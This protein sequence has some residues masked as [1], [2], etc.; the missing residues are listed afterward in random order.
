MH[1]T[2]PARVSR[3]G[4]IVMALASALLFGASTPLAKQLLS[5]VSPW[6][7]AGVLY[8]GSGLGLL[9][10]RLARRA[11]RVQLAAG[12]ARW[13]AAAVAC[14]GIAAPVLLMSGLAAMPASTASLLLNAEGVLTAVLAWV[15]FRENVDRRVATGMFAIVAGAVVLS[16]PGEWRLSELGP[17][18]LVLAACAAW[19]L[20]NNLTRKV[21]TADASFV[22]MVKGLAA[23]GSNVAI[24][25]AEGA[26]LPAPPLLAA[27]A[28]L[29]LLGYGLSLVLFVLALRHLGTARTGAYFSVAPFFGAALAVLWLGEPFGARL[30]IGGALMGLGVWLHVTERHV[31]E[32]RHEALEHDHE[33]R[34]DDGHHAHAHDADTPA[35]GRRGRHRHAHRH[36]AVAHSHAHFP[37]I[38]HRH[39]H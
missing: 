27:A 18:L 7:L 2:A 29:G 24:A 8:L 35:P 21:E 4:A 20:D 36:E 19:A 31:H 28:L 34:H 9:V 38:H 5:A 13:L 1:P 10:W 33:H 23:G 30:A 17:V 6:M 11:A 26:A 25:W 12:E 32:H 14:G 3:D 16:W 22:A 15:V 39:G 37:D